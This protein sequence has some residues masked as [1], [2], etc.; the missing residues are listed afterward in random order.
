MFNEVLCG[1]RSRGD[2]GSPLSIPSGCHGKVPP[3]G[4]EASKGTWVA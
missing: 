3:D 4:D 2:P 1:E